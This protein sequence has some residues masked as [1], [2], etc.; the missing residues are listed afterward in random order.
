MAVWAPKNGEG[1]HIQGAEL[2][3]QMPFTNYLGIYSNYAFADTNITEFAPEG[4]PYPMA[5]VARH[6]GT[7][8]L[9]VSPRKFE[10]RLGYKYHSGYTTGFEWT[11]SSLRYLDPEQNLS[12]NLAYHLTSKVS[13]RVQGNNLT[14][15]PLRLTQNN[16]DSDVRRYDVYGR[17]YLAD[18]TLKF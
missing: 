10:A 6:T 12:L 3:F 17:T 7:V 13:V 8:D 5:G 14:N 11:G 16:D 4:N 1:G 15:E 18:L 2:T 9:W